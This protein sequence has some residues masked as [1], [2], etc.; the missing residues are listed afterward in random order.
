M[1]LKG[2]VRSEYIVINEV[3]H[4]LEINTVPGMTEKSIV[5]QQVEALGMGLSHFLTKILEETEHHFKSN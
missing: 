3:P 2:I 4:L 1:G 5:P